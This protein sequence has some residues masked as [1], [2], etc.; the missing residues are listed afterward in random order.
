MTR[1]TVFAALCATLLA[2]TVS[3]ATESAPYRNNSIEPLPFSRY[4]AS[5]LYLKAVE[6]PLVYENYDLNNPVANSLA[7]RNAKLYDVDQEFGLNRVFSAQPYVLKGALGFGYWVAM[8][9]MDIENRTGPVQFNVDT[10]ISNAMMLDYSFDNNVRV[11]VVRT[12]YYNSSLASGSNTR[13]NMAFYI[14]KRF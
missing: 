7:A 14:G 3:M 12:T 10:T 5:P 9:D 2:S 1:R 6:V 13:W 4:L 11:G 8:G